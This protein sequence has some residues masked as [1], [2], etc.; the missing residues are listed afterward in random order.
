MVLLDNPFNDLAFDAQLERVLVASDWDDPDIPKRDNWRKEL[1]DGARFDPLRGREV[2]WP[3]AQLA[4]LTCRSQTLWLVARPDLRTQLA[5]V[6]GAVE[7]QAGRNSLLWRAP[8]RD[9]AS[10][11][12][13]PL[14]GGAGQ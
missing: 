14:A 12:G 3:I 13:Q 6:P 11:K 8:P 9:C 1:A 5:A 7:I 2:L 4:R 10:D